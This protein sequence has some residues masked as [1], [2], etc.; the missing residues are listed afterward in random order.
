MKYL[1][2]THTL[3][4][5]V[6]NTK[7]LSQKAKNIIIDEN[8]DIYVTHRCGLGGAYLIS[9]LPAK[10]HKRLRHSTKLPVQ[11]LLRRLATQ[12]RH[13]QAKHWKKSFC[14]S[15]GEKRESPIAE[16]NHKSLLLHL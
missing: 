12:E 13:G 3:I 6:Q 2:D 1:L 7:E 14:L 11:Y 15:T 8:N 9:D 5:A 10:N 16:K 4:W